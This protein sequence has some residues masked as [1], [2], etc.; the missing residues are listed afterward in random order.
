MG[1]GMVGGIAYGDLKES[2][3]ESVVPVAGVDGGAWGPE[4]S[5]MAELE[6]ARVAQDGELDAAWAEFDAETEAERE[7]REM[8]VSTDGRMYALQQQQQ[9]QLEAH[10]KWRAATLALT[11]GGLGSGSGSGPGPRGN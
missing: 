5:T 11:G 7:R 1:G 3:E 9:E 6:A 4:Y 2:Y 8:R 10:N